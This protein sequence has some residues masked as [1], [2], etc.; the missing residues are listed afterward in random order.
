M[1]PIPKGS[2]PTVHTIAA[3]CG[4]SA[5][6]VSLA[7]RDDPRLPEHTRHRIQQYADKV[8][9]RPNQVA[10]NLKRSATG[11]LGIILPSPTWWVD[12]LLLDVFYCQATERGYDLQLHLT[13]DDLRQEAKAVSRCLDGRVDALFLMASFDTVAEL[14]KEYPIAELRKGRVPCVI[15]ATEPVELHRVRRDRVAAVDLAARHMDEQGYDRLCL[16]IAVRSLEISSSA[17]RVDQF[18]STCKALG[19]TKDAANVYFRTAGF[20]RLASPKQAENSLFFNYQMHGR[21]GYEMMAHVL[22]EAPRNK[23]L[24]VICASDGL[25]AGALRYCREQGVDV[26]GQV[27]IIGADDTIAQELELS[28]FRWDHEDM[29]RFVLQTLQS[30]RPGQ[31]EPALEHLV[32]PTLV[33]RRSTQRQGAAAVAPTPV[34]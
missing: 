29:A 20:Q 32:Q 30:L 21:Y 27:G 13:H 4:V 14:P 19:R 3:A 18:A 2:N 6:T 10:R 9:Y 34:R 16:L 31:R 33:V 15:Y 25:A 28:S 11:S 12:T 17:G 23:S 1:A 24:G 26:P 8:G 7:L 5:T 22:Q